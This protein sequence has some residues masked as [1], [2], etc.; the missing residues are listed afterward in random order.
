MT[1]NERPNPWK[2]VAIPKGIE[3]N[4]YVF[5]KKKKTEEVKEEVKPT[6]I[7]YSNLIINSYDPI[8]TDTYAEGI[9]ELKKQGLVI[10]SFSTNL[11]ARIKQVNENPNTNLNHLSLWEKWLDS[12]CAIC[13]NGKDKFKIIHNCEE[14]VN[15][16]PNFNDHYIQSD[17]NKYKVD[18]KNV[19]EVSIKDDKYRQMLT[20]SEL[21]KHKGW[22]ALV[23]DDKQLLENYSK[24]VFK[25][26]KE[27][28][29]FWINTSPEKG[30]LRRVYVNIIGN[31]SSANGYNDLIYYA[32]FLQ[33][34]T[35]K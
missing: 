35:H 4:P 5:P 10:S 2:Y 19:F 20:Q 18:N 9:A 21:L 11:E 24:L 14:L 17:Y 28:M 13:Y 25:D 32:S 8:K 31:G 1:N 6:Q 22:L 3:N 23:Q 15:I 33:L 12:N 34:V 7:D 16:D 26:R 29:C 27:A 30:E